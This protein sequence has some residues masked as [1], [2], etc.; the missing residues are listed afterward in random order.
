MERTNSQKGK[1]LMLLQIFAQETDEQH[2]LSVPA[3][4]ERLADAG[5]QAERK[6]V[7]E[8][9]HTLQR[10][11][12]D[13][14]LHRGRGYYLGERDFQLAELKL[15]V[16]AVQASKFITPQ[17]SQAL[18][19]KLARQTSRYQARTLQRQVYVAGKAKSA[20][21]RVY[22]TIDAIYEAIGQNKQVS[23]RYFDLNQRREKV[24]RKGGAVYIV[25][26]YALV[27]DNDNY[28]LVAYDKTSGRLRHYRV[29]KM[30]RIAV[31]KEA[32]LGR[33]VYEAEDPARYTDIHFGMFQGEEKEVVLRCQDWTAHVLIDRFGDNLEMYPDDGPT[34]RAVVRV[35]VSP[36]FFGWLFGLNG[37]AVVLAP[38]PVR[39]QMEQMLTAQLEQYQK[40]QN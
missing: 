31:R 30:D 29:D 2:P 24:Y 20:N 21:E 5:I 14:V 22:Y 6:S 27:R 38:E 17:K 37:G 18:I 15:L 19:D 39:F 32:R 16:D 3:L 34:F 1:L 36:Q 33:E 23:F 9:I 28:Y 25:S 11:G 7:Y 4:L 35:V 26:P 40:G 13:I 10:Y 8:D 12:Y